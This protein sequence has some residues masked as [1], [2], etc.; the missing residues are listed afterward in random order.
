MSYSPTLTHCCCPAAAEGSDDKPTEELLLLSLCSLA[1]AHTS[2]STDMDSI[3][4]QLVGPQLT[5]ATE[6]LV[7]ALHGSW[8]CQQQ[9][10]QLQQQ[11]TAAH[12][13][14][15]HL[16]QQRQQQQQHQWQAPVLQSTA[17]SCFKALTSLV[18]GLP[19]G[20]SKQALGVSMHSR[21]P[22]HQQQLQHQH[23]QVDGQQ[24]TAAGALALSAAEGASISSASAGDSN[25]SQVPSAPATA[26]AAALCQGRC[27]HPYC[28]TISQEEQQLPDQAAAAQERQCQA[29]FI[30]SQLLVRAS[31]PVLLA[32]QTAASAAGEQQM[33]CHLYALQLLT[34]VCK[35]LLVAFPAAVHHQ[36]ISSSGTA[37]DDSNPAAAGSSAS[38]SEGRSRDVWQ[39]GVLL[40]QLSQLLQQLPGHLLQQ[41]CCLQL[42]CSSVAAA[43]AAGV[44]PAVECR[45]SIA[46]V[47][48]AASANGTAY[49]QQ[50]L[51][52]LQG[53][54]ARAVGAA[55]ASIL[56]QQGGA[57][58][59]HTSAA[60]ALATVGLQQCPAVLAASDLDMLLSLTLT[61]TRTCHLKQ[62]TAVLDWI[63][64]LAQ[65]AYP[66]QLQHQ[67]RAAG[68][69]EGQGNLTCRALHHQLE[70]GVGAQLVLSLLLAASGG[71]PPDVVLP[72]SLCLHSVWLSVGRRVF[73][74]W[75]TAA[76]MQLAPESAPWVKQR[77]AAK[78]AF[79]ADLTDAACLTDTTRFKRIVK[80]FCGGKKKGR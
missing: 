31:Q 56:Q 21:Y 65:A 76:V 6:E 28:Q 11:L 39:A 51:Q 8:P 45:M 63:Q 40:Q 9:P 41:P 80:N 18:T 22:R 27:S 3:L 74:S 32:M 72:I 37:T 38:N 43:T 79:V 5:A 77:H 47:L 70:S 1:V 71:M 7:A 68:A 25:S 33:L 26:A 19:T 55:A 10:P 34:A 73:G 67:Q 46:A 15:W 66:Q 69:D 53:L 30:V 58:P 14:F 54:T 75:V 42:L 61:A 16:K 57:D 50:L 78:V 60:L 12:G 62:C 17:I 35:F 48:G 2:N 36:V 52:M 4:L 23:A 24:S 44:L 13:G 59:D 20:V 29:C 64:V 49:Q